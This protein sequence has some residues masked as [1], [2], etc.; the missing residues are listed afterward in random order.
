LLFW[1]LTATVGTTTGNF[2]ADDELGRNQDP[3]WRWF[4]LGVDAANGHHA[5]GQS[6][7]FSTILTL[8]SPD[9]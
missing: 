8:P 1:Q 2:G 5:G 6:T 4:Q 3:G 9:R 7:E